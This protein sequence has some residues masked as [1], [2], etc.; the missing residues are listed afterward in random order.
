MRVVYGLQ[1]PLNV[2]VACH[3]A[4]QSEYLE[5]WIVRVNAHVHVAFIAYRHDSGKKIAHVFAQLVLAD[6]VIARQKFSEQLYRMLVALLE[7]AAHEALCLDNDILYELML[8]LGS[9][10]LAQLLHLFHHVSA[11]GLAVGSQ[12]FKLRP[13]VFGSL[14]LQY[15]D[16]EVGKFGYAEVEVCRAVRV[17]MV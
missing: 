7:I 4:W 13:V 17:G 6:V 1:E 16:V 8:S 9:H 15:I 10:L 11:V 2:V 5:G 3:D 12:H 14:T